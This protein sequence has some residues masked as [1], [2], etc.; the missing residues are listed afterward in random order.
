MS[1]SFIN[2]TLILNNTLGINTVLI[3]LKPLAQGLLI[4]LYYFINTPLIRFSVKAK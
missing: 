4:R 3:R 1:N 2:I